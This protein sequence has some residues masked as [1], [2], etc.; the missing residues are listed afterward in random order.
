MDPPGILMLR[1][2][3][4]VFEIIEVQPESMKFVMEKFDFDGL[5]KALTEEPKKCPVVGT[6]YKKD[7]K[8]LGHAMVADSALKGCA[9]NEWFVNCKNSYRNRQSTP[10]MF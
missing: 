10:G 4:I 9:P 7:G 5:E 8:K 1:S 2:V 3:R 6:Y